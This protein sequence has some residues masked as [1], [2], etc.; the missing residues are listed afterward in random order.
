M[1]APIEV[2][3]FKARSG[4]AAVPASCGG[5]LQGSDLDQPARDAGITGWGISLTSTAAGQVGTP[6]IVGG[7]VPRCV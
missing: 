2:L 3:G 4:L 6:D 1:S 5:V 7:G